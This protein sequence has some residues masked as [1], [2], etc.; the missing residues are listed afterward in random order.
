MIKTLTLDISRLS[1]GIVPIALIPMAIPS[2]RYVSKHIHKTLVIIWL[3]LIGHRCSYYGFILVAFLFAT[4][5]TKLVIFLLDVPHKSIMVFAISFGCFTSD[6][7]RIWIK[8]LDLT[9]VRANDF[10]FISS[11]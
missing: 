2:R 5:I 1:T 9:F 3:R 7:G 4:L 11:S 10:W 8:S 6:I